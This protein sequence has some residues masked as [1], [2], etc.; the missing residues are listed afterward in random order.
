MSLLEEA[1]EDFTILNKAV[2]DDGYGGV[3]TN[4]TDGAKIKGAIVCE[5]SAQMKTA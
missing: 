4:W 5:S 3:T 1:Y 2:V